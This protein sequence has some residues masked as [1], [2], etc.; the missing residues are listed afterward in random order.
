MGVRSVGMR[1][2]RPY[3]PFRVAL[4][5]SEGKRDARMAERGQMTVEL[6]VVFP[7]AVIVALVAVNALLFI[8]ECASFDR[9]A[10]QAIRV[11]ATAPSYGQDTEQSRALVEESLRESFARDNE[12]VSVNVTAAGLGLVRFEAELVYHPTLFGMGLR[13]EVLGV[14]LSPLRH[15]TGLTVDPYKPGVVI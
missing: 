6:A 2:F 13:S 5:R 4:K 11:H 10:D 3:P 14:E 7:I 15:S 9:I 12:D 1:G 8:S